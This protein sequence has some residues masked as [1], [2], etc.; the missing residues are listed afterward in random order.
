MSCLL[1]KE[2]GSLPKF[3]RVAGALLF[4]LCPIAQGEKRR[5]GQGLADS[6]PPLTR[7]QRPGAR[8][9]C[10]RNARRISDCGSQRA[11]M[12]CPVTQSVHSDDSPLAYKWAPSSAAATK[13]SM[14]G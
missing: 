5:L 9:G 1:R 7:E 14:H 3:V 12:T 8:L 11:C 6:G 10:K 13:F 2:S 4:R